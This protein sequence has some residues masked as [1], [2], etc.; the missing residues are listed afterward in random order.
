[1]DYVI[2]TATAHLREPNGSLLVYAGER[3]AA[4]DPVVKR[5]PG[6]FGPPGDDDIRRSVPVVEA[7]TAAPGEKRAST[8]KK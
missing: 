3:W 1:M 5:H 7:A 6:N 4:D 8:R 2:A